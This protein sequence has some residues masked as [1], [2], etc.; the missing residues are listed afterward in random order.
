MKDSH[1]QPART[2][3]TVGTIVTAILFGVTCAMPAAAQEVLPF[4]PKPSGSK[5]L[6]TMQESIYD[7]LPAE[8]HL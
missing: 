4:P 3:R 7:P 8:R 2:Q 6:P 1:T 5:A